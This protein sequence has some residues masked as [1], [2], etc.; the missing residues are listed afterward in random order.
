MAQSDAEIELSQYVLTAPE[1]SVEEGLGDGSDCA[2]VSVVPSRTTVAS[3][4][5]KDFKKFIMRGC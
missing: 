4:P 5:V 2:N 3:K 1:E